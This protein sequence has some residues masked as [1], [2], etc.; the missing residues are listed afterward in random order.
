MRMTHI[1]TDA[2]D[3]KSESNT[4]G[5]KFFA[6]EINKT[7]R[8]GAADF[9]R[10]GQLLNDAKAELQTDAFNALVKTKLAFD[11]SV[12]VKLMGIADKPMLCAHE[13]KLPPCW[14]TLYELSK[15]AD[16][17]L[18]A[19]LA[20]G[21]IHSGMERKDALALRKPKKKT[22]T[23]DNTGKAGTSSLNKAAWVKATVEE[24]RHFINAIGADSL[25]EALS[26]TMRAE[27]RRRVAGQR[28]TAMSALDEIITKAMRQAL[29]LQ[30]ASKVKDS[31]APGV[32]AALNAVNNKLE[33]GGLDLNNV[34]IAVDP[35]TTRK[36]A[37]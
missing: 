7:W 18:E 3:V 10:C 37:A 31:P 8:K 9:I 27:L 28:R 16:E 24:R 25:C 11:R 26:I 36:H 23:P 1:A 15:L 6:D 19:K 17:V 14:T 20:D 33:A 4:R 5:W 29:S 35:T 12:A 22:T 34:T 13:H 2:V 30:K 32:A 21:T